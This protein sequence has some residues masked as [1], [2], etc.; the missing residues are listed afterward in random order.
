MSTYLADSSLLIALV[1]RDHVHHAASIA[2]FASAKPDIATCPVTQGALLRFLMREGH[3]AEHAAEVLD[4]FRANRWHHFWADD[5]EYTAATLAGTRGHRQ[6]ADS[7][8]VGLAAHHGGTLA[9]LDKGLAAVH[10]EAILVQ[11]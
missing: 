2:W 9:T 7:Y 5:I 1:T 4:A 3:S 6:V 11:S 10:P 8:L